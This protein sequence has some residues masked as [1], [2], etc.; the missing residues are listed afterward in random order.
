MLKVYDSYTGVSIS[1]IYILYKM[2]VNP[3]LITEHNQVTLQLT[4]IP[5]TMD[6][7]DQSAASNRVE[8]MIH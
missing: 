8:L 6:H 2:F 3:I 1:G 4:Q 5:R 7:V